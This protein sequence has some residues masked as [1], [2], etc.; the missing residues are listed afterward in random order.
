MAVIDGGKPP[1]WVLH[2]GKNER[3]ESRA[4]SVAL[5]VSTE[6]GKE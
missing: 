1:L 2:G 3:D 6:K 5:L 4:G